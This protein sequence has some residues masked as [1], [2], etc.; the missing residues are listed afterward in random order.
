MRIL[1]HAATLAAALVPAIACAR[2]QVIPADQVLAQSVVADKSGARLLVDGRSIELVTDPSDPALSKLGDGAFHPMDAAQ[3]EAAIREIAGGPLP[4]ARV[5]VLPY[6]RRDVLESCCEG[7]VVFL[8]P[9]I[10]PVRPEHVHATVVHELGHAVENTLCPDGSTAWNDYL[11]RRSL[12]DPRFA[13]SAAHAD[14]PREIFAEDF[15]FLRGGAL[16]TSSGTIENQSLPLPSGVGGLA[17]WF[18][19]LASVRPSPGGG[20]DL[21][22]IAAPNPFRASTDGSVVIRFAAA[23]PVPGSAQASVFDATGRRVRALLGEASG[24]A[25]EFRWD[26]MDGSG[27]RVASG[28]YFVRLEARAASAPARVHILR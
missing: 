26:G 6:P 14:R 8:A 21:A 3:V 19:A 16:A 7:N 23:A 28:V 12:R 2:I 4:D 24:P 5:Y 18:L 11:T 20:A 10:R 15:R 17:E 25:L 1:R 9:G 22:P 13:S 27:R